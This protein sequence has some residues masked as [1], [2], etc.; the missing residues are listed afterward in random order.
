MEN[1]FSIREQII[2]VAN[3]LFVYTDNRQWQKLMEEVFTGSVLFDMSSAGGG[4]PANISAKEV[5]DKWEKGFEGIDAI[6]HQAG[7]YLVTLN[8]TEA[9]VHAY[10][11]AIHFKKAAQHGK[12]REFVGSYDLLLS[13]IPGKGWRINTFKYNLK[14]I[15][16]NVD[17]L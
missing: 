9:A 5:C 6:H 4:E 11:I 3:K 12:T 14:Y 16:G 10:A 15:D 2:E 7:N 8:T 1:K 13:D 17:L